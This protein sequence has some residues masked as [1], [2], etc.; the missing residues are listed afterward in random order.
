MGKISVNDNISIDNL[1][2]RK[3]GIEKFLHELQSRGWSRSG[4]HTVLRQLLQE[5][6]AHSNYTL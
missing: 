1:K 2:N 3:D 5:G 6:S 4:F